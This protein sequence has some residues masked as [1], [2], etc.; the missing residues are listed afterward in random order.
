MDNKKNTKSY[1]RLTF[2]DRIQI[3]RLLREGESFRKIAQVMH[4]HPNS[5]KREV[6]QYATPSN[7]GAM[8]SGGTNRCLRRHDCHTV[9]TLCDKCVF[10]TGRACKYCTRCNFVCPDFLEET[11]AKL[12]KAPFVCNGCVNEPKCTLGKMYY[13][14]QPANERALVMRKESR[15]GANT[16]DEDLRC[17]ERLL[18]PR[19]KKGQSINH[20]LCA[21]ADELPMSVK[22]IYRYI[23]QGLMCVR[24]GD[25]PRKIYIKPRKKKPTL[26]H[27]VDRKCRLGRT[28][29]DYD[30]F[31]SAE[32]PLPRILMDTVIGK[33]GGKVI[34]TIHFCESHFM[35]ARLLP[36]K[37]S[38][39]VIDAFDALSDALGYANFRELLPVILTDNGTEFSNPN[40]LEHFA[41][42]TPRTRI[43]YCDAYN[44]NQKAEIERNHEFLRVYLPKHE[45]FDD[46]QQADLDLMLSHI[47]SYTRP[48]LG[49]K[50]PIGLFAHRYSP[51]ILVRLN[52]TPIKPDKICLKRN[53]L[54]RS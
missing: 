26:E 24:N 50:T 15:R 42:G 37:T 36:N 20:I 35:I 43:F 27:K 33:P 38:K 2:N 52:Q 16:T 9:R 46:L 47:N 22:T 12:K 3:E 29:G 13:L 8:I 28:L 34:L 25:L 6:A 44:S 32:G 39:A 23:D 10:T 5:I 17:M 54:N 30:R 51:E 18:A 31:C 19:I 4:R 53:L 21:H 14:A 48:K 7:K 1:G 11:C 49:N 41:D 45:P 40:R